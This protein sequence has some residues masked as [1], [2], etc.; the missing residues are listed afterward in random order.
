M[1]DTI[2]EDVI[3]DL[4]S[5]SKRGITKYGV[6]LDRDDLTVLEWHQ[7]HYEELLDAALYTKRIIEEL[8]KQQE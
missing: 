8:K 3:N 2:V 4:L 6:T 5:R 1:I 7:H